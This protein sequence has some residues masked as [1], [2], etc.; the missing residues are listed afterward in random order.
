MGQGEREI[1]SVVVWAFVGDWGGLVV[2]MIW[3]FVDLEGR[4][5]EV[6]VAFL[7]VFGEIDVVLKWEWN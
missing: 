2:M 4:N 6:L 3:R 1:V 5:Q 7:E